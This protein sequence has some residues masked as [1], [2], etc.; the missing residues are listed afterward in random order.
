MGSSLVSLFD[1]SPEQITEVLE[2]A[3]R[4][5]ALKRQDKLRLL[6]RIRRRLALLFE[7]PSLRT[8]VSFEAGMAQLAG[9]RDLPAPADV[10]LG[11]R[12]P[13]ADVAGALSRWVDVIAVR[14]SQ[15]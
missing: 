14:T 3:A 2:V 13:V 15:A 10:G 11:M 8:R 6:L 4:F 7:K 1:V 12:E 5:K 9:Q